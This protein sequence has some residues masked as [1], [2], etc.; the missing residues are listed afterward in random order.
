MGGFYLSQSSY[1]KL[2][3]KTTWHVVVLWIITYDVAYTTVFRKMKTLMALM[4]EQEY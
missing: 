2:W 1:N 3:L 4:T